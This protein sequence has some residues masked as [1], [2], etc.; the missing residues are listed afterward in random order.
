V[1]FSYLH[2]LSVAA[3]GALGASL[4][5]LFLIFLQGGAAGIFVLNV[6]GSLL[7]GLLLSSL[8][9]KAPALTAFAGTGLLGAL[10]TYSTFSGDLVRLFGSSVQSAVLY[11]AASL[12]FGVLAF[13]LGGWIGRAL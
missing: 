6:A 10:T 12:A 5:Y 4:R 3:G 1:T 9:S 2:L 13:L 7:L 8:G 11:G